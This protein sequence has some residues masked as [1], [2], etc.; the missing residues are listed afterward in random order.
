MSTGNP[1]EQLRR[2]MQSH[3]SPTA[4][5]ALAEEHRRAGH[6]A[7]AIEVCRDGLAQYPAYVSA[8][9]TL[10]RALLDSGDAASAVA[11]LEQAVAQ[12]PDNLAAARAL[13]SA[14][15]ALGDALPASAGDMT[16]HTD[17]GTASVP[18]S[19]VASALFD[20]G[21]DSQGFGDYAWSTPVSDTHDAGGDAHADAGVSALHVEL[22]PAHTDAPTML[23][24]PPVLQGEEPAGVW[25]VPVLD[26]EPA[27]PDVDVAGE[28][29][30][31]PAFADGSG[32]AGHPARDGAHVEP[33][34]PVVDPGV[35]D[36]PTILAPLVDVFAAESSGNEPS[37][38]SA[39]S[40]EADADAQGSE[41]SPVEASAVTADESSPFW[42]GAFGG[43][44]QVESPAP[45]S[46][47]DTDAQEPETV[48]DS[49]HWAGHAEEETGPWAIPDSPSATWALSDLHDPAGADTVP[50]TSVAAEDVVEPPPLPIAF[51]PPPLPAFANSDALAGVAA[52][53]PAFADG[54][55][56]AGY[57][58]GSD[59]VVDESAEPITVVEVAAAPESIVVADAVSETV[60][61]A[62]AGDTDSSGAAAGEVVDGAV[63]DAVSEPASHDMWA[64][65]LKSALGEVFAQAGQSDSLEPPAHPSP[66]VRAAMADAAVDAAV[67]DAVLNDETMAPTLVSLQQLLDSVRA[68]RAALFHNEQ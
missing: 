55:G 4:F 40:A 1:L 37:A 13:E 45:F 16:S 27:T 19:I 28:A 30:G 9:V 10:G 21:N 60:D 8:R 5:A 39:A 61:V 23:M 59:E 44:S 6:F 57:P 43:E 34:A 7:D 42:S 48:V 65:S 36:A 52:G 53:F 68:R 22:D 38:W 58:A 62:A 35:W 56:E 20:A 29:A 2:R 32:A 3:A 46:R 15:A 54:S 47:W 18:H 64:G 63:A 24:T 17:D 33:A 67:D 26:V 12:A 41:S 49:P 11:E 31:F 66:A 51:E 50:F 25:P 14:K